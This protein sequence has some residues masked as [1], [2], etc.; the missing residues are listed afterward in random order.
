MFVFQ[1]RCF[2]GEMGAKRRTQSLDLVGMHPIEPVEQ[3]VA[4]S[5]SSRP[6]IAFHRGEK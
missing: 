2:A 6:S 5:F 4:D 3:R 1:V